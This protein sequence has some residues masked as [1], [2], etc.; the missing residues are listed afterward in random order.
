MSRALSVFSLAA[1][2]LIGA[3]LAF[4][5]GDRIAQWAATLQAQTQTQMAAAL[6]ALHAGDGGALLGLWG[7]CFS[8]GLAHAMGPGHGKFVLGAYGAA[9]DVST[10]RMASIAMAA[11]LAQGAMA[12][13]LVAI[14]FALLGM[15]RPQ[16]SDLAEG[17]MTQAALWAVLAIGL[18]LCFRGARGLWAMRRDH[19][20]HPHDHSH[21][22][23]CPTCGHAHG[24]SREAVAAAVT[25]REVAA[26]IA[27]IALRPCSGA[28]FVMVLTW[29]MG[30]IWQG[31]GA[32]AAMAI[33]TGLVTGG[34]ALMASHAR[35]GAMGWLGRLGPV[36]FVLELCAGL[37]VV[38]LVTAALRG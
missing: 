18:W 26:L 21:D 6:R 7:L 11:S 34:V 10:A 28:I 13:A 32:V 23:P 4:G 35:K 31:L 17:V 5:T 24:P 9:R 22:T 37:L 29:R 15:A 38:V 20:H 14:G 27:A 12:V 19:A 1:L 25:P 36:A 16:V 8:Y 33:G 2:I 3:L 30:L